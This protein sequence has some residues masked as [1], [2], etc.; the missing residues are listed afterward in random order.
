LSRGGGGAFD[1]DP[2]DLR[3]ELWGVKV[4]HLLWQ[5]IGPAETIG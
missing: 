4:V 3:L 2:H 5:R 1:N